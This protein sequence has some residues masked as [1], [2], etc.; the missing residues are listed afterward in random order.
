[1][2]KV[3]DTVRKTGLF[4]VGFFGGGSIPEE[5]VA[6]LKAAGVTGQVMMHVSREEFNRLAPSINLAIS[7]KLNKAIKQ[8]TDAFYDSITPAVK[9]G[10][11]QEFICPLSMELMQDPVVAADGHVYDRTSLEKWFAAGKKTSPL[12]GAPLTHTDLIPCT[13]LKSLIQPSSTSQ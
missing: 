3:I 10:V 2:P 13:T 1:M 7:A 11:P 4:D 5:D 9:K 6:E 12:T 8:M